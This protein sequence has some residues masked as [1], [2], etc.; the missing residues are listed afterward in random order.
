[1]KAHIYMKPRL[2]SIK[3]ALNLKHLCILKYI[4]EFI[5]NFLQPAKNIVSCITQPLFGAKPQTG[6]EVLNS[7]LTKLSH[8]PFSILNNLNR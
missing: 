3:D 7:Q 2:K 6:F 8:T 5:S 4:I 1:M